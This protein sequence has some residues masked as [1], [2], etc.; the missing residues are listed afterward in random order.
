MFRLTS[1]GAGMPQN[2]IDEELVDAA[3]A[4]DWEK[5][6]KLLACGANPRSGVSAALWCGVNPGSGVSAAL[7]CAAIAGSVECVRALLPV[8]DPKAN[9]SYALVLAAQNGHA[10]CVKLL[11]PVSDAKSKNSCALRLAAL[12][13][14]SECVRLLLASSDPTEND[15]EALRWAAELGRVECIRL[16]LP[17]CKPL[18]ELV[19]ILKQVVGSG[20]ATAAALLISEE[21]RLLDGVDLCQCVVEAIEKG[22]LDMASLLSSI[23]DKQELLSIAPNIPKGGLGPARL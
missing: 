21:P 15:S 23:M 18:F 9:E 19:G 20:S 17:A 6:L 8:S 13:G 16:L 10:E 1:R 14:S 5:V 3:S 22:H 4:G 11:L 12:E 2:N 7:W